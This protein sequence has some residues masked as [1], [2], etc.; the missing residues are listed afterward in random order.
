MKKLSQ[1]LQKFDQRIKQ[2]LKV[3]QSEFTAQL[4]EEKVEK[5]AKKRQP[6]TSAWCL[7]CPLL[8]ANLGPTSRLNVPPKLEPHRDHGVDL[9][10]MAVQQKRFV[11]PMND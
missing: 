8:L 9:R 10:R 3:P 6:K 5:A 7:S 1:D 4:D 2:L 11:A